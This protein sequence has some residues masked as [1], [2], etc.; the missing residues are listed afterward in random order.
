M[1]NRLLPP[2]ATIWTRYGLR[3]K[4]MQAERMVLWSKIAFRAVAEM[5][6]S[7]QPLYRFELSWSADKPLDQQRLEV[8]QG[9]RPVYA[10]GR[11]SCRPGTGSG[12][13]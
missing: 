2:W 9:R 10:G 8:P 6:L 11:S 12:G 5:E 7:D 3:R 4:Q 13:C 1:P